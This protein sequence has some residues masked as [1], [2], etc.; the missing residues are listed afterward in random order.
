MYGEG[1]T[2]IDEALPRA[3]YARTVGPGCEMH[4]LIGNMEIWRRTD[5]ET[6][7]QGRYDYS[8]FMDLP[9][10]HICTVHIPT[11]PDFFAFMRLY[12]GIA[13]AQ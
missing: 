2:D 4:F 11:I 10:D 3:G 5:G 7:L 8:V 6:G 12:G 1:V 13:Q 9:D